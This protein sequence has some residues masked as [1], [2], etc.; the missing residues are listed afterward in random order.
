MRKKKNF[1]IG[2]VIL[3]I[4]IAFIPAINGIHQKARGKNDFNDR[5]VNDFLEKINIKLKIRR[6]NIEN[7]KKNIIEIM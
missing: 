5:Y 6:K 7:M 4:L 1:G 3:I 2:A